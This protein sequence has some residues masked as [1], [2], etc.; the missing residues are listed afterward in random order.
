MSCFKLNSLFSG[1]YR[2]LP[3][4]QTTTILLIISGSFNIADATLVIAPIAI[5]YRGS[6]SEHFKA[7]SI[8]LSEAG[9]LI[10]FFSKPIYFVEPLNTKL[11]FFKFYFFK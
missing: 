5:T 3:P 10:G 2:A 4:S 1:Q 7:L 9:E 8:I 6:F 11:F